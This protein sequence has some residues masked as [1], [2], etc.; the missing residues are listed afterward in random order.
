M[1]AGGSHT[2]QDR[3]LRKDTGEQADHTDIGNVT[4]KVRFPD[5]KE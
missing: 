1:D 3:H 5:K 4:G 2:Q